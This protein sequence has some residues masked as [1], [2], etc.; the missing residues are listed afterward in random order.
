LKSTVFQSL[1]RMKTYCDKTVYIHFLN[2]EDPDRPCRV[3]CQD[4]EVNHRFYMVNGEDGWFPFGTDCS[5]G[6]LEKRAY[7][8]SGKCLVSVSTVVKHIVY[9]PCYMYVFPH[10]ACI[11]IVQYKLLQSAVNIKIICLTIMK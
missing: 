7:C 11:Q 3:A 1:Y 5:R 2:T 8:V 9:K 4:D 6:V 10:N